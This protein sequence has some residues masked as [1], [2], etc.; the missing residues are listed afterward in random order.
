[1]WIREGAFTRIRNLFVFA[2]ILFIAAFA[3]IFVSLHVS[4]RN[5]CETIPDI[6]DDFGAARRG[7][8]IIRFGEPHY[9]GR[10]TAD[11]V[12]LP[13]RLEMPLPKSLIGDDMKAAA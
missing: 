10:P 6:L 3:I 7:P 4:L 11:I 1:M 12:Q 2:S 13:L 5:A 9:A 8:R